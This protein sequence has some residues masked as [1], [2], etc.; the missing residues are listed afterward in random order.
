MSISV[1]D[2]KLLVKDLHTL[3]FVD[4]CALWRF[5]REIFLVQVCVLKIHVATPLKSLNN[6][7]AVTITH[8][9]RRDRSKPLRALLLETSAVNLKLFALS[10]SLSSLSN[11]TTRKISTKDLDRYQD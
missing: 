8:V 7:I 10:G 9:V 4:F 2:V 3:I 11:T 5:L 6:L 1:G